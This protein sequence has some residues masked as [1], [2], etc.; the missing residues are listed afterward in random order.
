M[1][2]VYK[3]FSAVNVNDVF[4]DS[5]KV[6]YAEFSSWFDKKSANGEKAYVFYSEAGNVEGFLYLKKEKEAMGDVVPALPEAKRI[7]IGT[8]KINPHGTRLGELFIK[9][10]IDYGIYS[11]ADEI[12][13]TV[14]AHHEYL[15]S[16][17]WRYGFEEVAHK[18][19]QNGTELVMI[20]KL[21]GLVGDVRRQYPFVDGSARKFL[22]ALYPEWHSRLLP[23]SILNTENPVNIVKDISHTNSIHKI[24]L[25]SMSGAESLRKGD[26]LVI[27]RTSDKK[28]PA[29]YRSVATSICVVEEVRNIQEF[30]S[31]GDFIKY[32]SSYSIF[33][34]NELK[35][36]YASKKYPIIIKFTY[37]YALP[38]RVNRAYMIEEL[39][40]DPSRYWGFFQ[41]SETEF[42]G[43]LD[44][45]E[46]NE[47]IVVD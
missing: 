21:S 14:F 46:A 17:F 25:T 18:T 23:D 31:E 15:V 35:R 29:H 44:R 13:V 28:G 30:G 1:A 24:Y 41:L 4:F 36:F 42:R 39:G 7:K 19:T 5:L 6:D 26:V 32:A 47:S 10:A 33:D 9:K 27:Y 37:N 12:Y 8:L 34:I 38:K 3:K 2:L 11:G 40:M 45:G 20:K 43:V 16:M 22:L